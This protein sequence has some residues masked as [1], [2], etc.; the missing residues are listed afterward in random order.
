[1]QKNVN[2]DPLMD[3]II[4]ATD[5]LHLLQQDPFE[6]LIGYVLSQCSNIPRIRRNLEDIA[7]KWGQRVVF[8]EKEFYLFPK[9]EELLEITEQ[10]LVELKLGYRAK[11]IRNIIQKYPSF[12]EAEMENSADFNQQ[13][14]KI[15]GIGQK[16]ADCIQL[17]AYGDLSWFPVDTWMRKFMIRY[18]ISPFKS[19]SK[20]HSQKTE[21]PENMAQ[22]IHIHAADS[23]QLS[24]RNI[25]N[26]E[27]SLIGRQ[28]FGSWAGYAQELIYYYARCVDPLV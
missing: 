19:P 27:L 22:D 23:T 14:Q 7:R 4:R 9:R 8:E 18:Y 11:Y 3:K 12:L 16:V 2:I 6:C 28:L 15:A 10:D 1:M 5:G 13:L 21:N 20:K 17:F 25:S 26:K 24:P